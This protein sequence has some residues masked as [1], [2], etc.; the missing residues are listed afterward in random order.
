MASRLDSV[1]P[2]QSVRHTK[3]HL[4]S[5]RW[6]FRYKTLQIN[7]LHNGDVPSDAFKGLTNRRDTAKSSP[8]F[9]LGIVQAGTKNYLKFTSFKIYSEIIHFFD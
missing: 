6:R 4:A 8:S 3:I 9:D 2:S 1:I 7:G 5:I